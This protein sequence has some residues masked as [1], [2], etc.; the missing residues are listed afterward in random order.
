[1]ATK[2]TTKTPKPHTKMGV[3]VTTYRKYEQIAGNRKWSITE[4][5]EQIA[6]DYAKRHRIKLSDDV[7]SGR[8]VASA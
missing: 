2:S 3:R 1:M 5:A 7:S 6:Q 4:T 8:A